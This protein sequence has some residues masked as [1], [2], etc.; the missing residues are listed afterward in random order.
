MEEKTMKNRR[1]KQILAL[2]MTLVISFAA[3]AP[4]TVSAEATANGSEVIYSNDF[5]SGSVETNV[6]KYVFAAQA[7][8]PT[9]ANGMLTLTKVGDVDA[10]VGIRPEQLSQHKNDGEKAMKGDLTLSFKLKLESAISLGSLKC[11]DYAASRTAVEFLNVSN[12]SIKTSGVSQAL[13]LNEWQTIEVVFNYNEATAKFGSYTV[14]LNGEELNTVAI[15]DGPAYINSFELFRWA[16]AD[17]SFAL[18]DV[19]LGFGSGNRGNGVA[20]KVYEVDFEGVTQVP[21][22]AARLNN[23]RVMNDYLNNSKTKVQNG[24]L[25][26]VSNGAQSYID[27]NPDK[28]F[29][30]IGDMNVSMVV[31]P[32]GTG[33]NNNF[34]A[35]FFYNTATGTNNYD[36]IKYADAQNKIKI[37]GNTATLSSYRFST[38]ESVF[39]YDY[40]A[41]IYTSVDV[42]VNGE[43]IGSEDISA[44]GATQ[45]NWVRIAMTYT[46]GNGIEMDSFAVTKGR[47][48]TYKGEA[49]VTE[50]IGYQ[51]TAANTET[52]TF[53]LRLLAITTDE[54]L[55]KYENVGFKVSATYGDTTKT[56]PEELGACKSVYKSVIASA[57]IDATYT[58][59]T[60]G[61][62]AIYALNCLNLPTNGGA[63]TFTVTTYY[64]IAGQAS[65]EERTFTFTVDPSTDIPK[66]GVN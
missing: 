15:A 13:T 28:N 51:A 1:T 54:D 10:Y 46:A 49:A 27:A 43:L 52:N 55:S 34:L 35:R 31:R 58:A 21:T 9:V 66:G 59:E 45:I 29:G 42:Y 8:N 32:V 16:T 2:L 20:A 41:G 38:V 65:V 61:G 7:Y 47:A 17:A 39:H 26:A 25:T 53:N 33:W 30:F 12:G 11:G 6:G 23:L 63:I 5:S 56:L 24:I 57:G 64:T 36:L 48:L 44:K 40:A 50:F 19:Y 4:A 3:F 62:S 22:N 37:G 14:L 18:D 60:L